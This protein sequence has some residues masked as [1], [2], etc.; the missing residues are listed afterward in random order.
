MNTSTQKTYT[1][2]PYLVVGVLT[3]LFV[4]ILYIWSIMKA[5]LAAEFGW[6]AAELTLNYTLSLCFFCTGAIVGGV[7]TNKIGHKITITIA[8]I[9]A[10][11][12]FVLV[13]QLSGESVVML[14]LING[15][16]G[17]FGVGISY[18]VV[19]STTN[20]W[21]PDKRGLCNGVLQVGIGISGLVLGGVAELLIG[22]LGW[23]STFTIMGI[24]LGVALI[25]AGF[26]MR[27]PPSDAS[28]LQP[29]ASSQESGSVKAEDYTAGQMLRKTSFWSTFIAVTFIAAAGNS[30]ISFAKEF[31]MSV[32]ATAA[33]STIL[34]GVLSICNGLGRFLSGLLFD[35]LGR[36]KTILLV[37]AASILAVVCLI[38]SVLSS[39]L[40][41]CVAGM[42]FA[43]LSYGGCATANSAFIAAPFGS[44]YFSVNFGIASA[45]IMG[46]ALMSSLSGTLI[47]ASGSYVESFVLLLGLSLVA[48]ILNLRIKRS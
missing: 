30:V 36:R 22:A 40:F 24:V 7:L 20:A 37:N 6:T 35:I 48:V 9:L 3:M 43:G 11:A 13:S 45:T 16:M 32:G 25:V 38:V 19:I 33:L 31:S 10:G 23:R 27:A 5:P 18:N 15:V 41:M 46:A 42:C 8:A 2:W 17:G 29:K 39:T 4:G 44:K 47:T 28:F 26:I 21:F 12:G 14:Y 34:V 1:R